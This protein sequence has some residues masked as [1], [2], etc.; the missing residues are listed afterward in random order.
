MGCRLDNLQS[1]QNRCNA[2]FVDKRCSFVTFTYDR[3][4]LKYNDNALY[5][6]LSQDEI[7][8]W[9]DNLRH[10][11]KNTP[12]SHYHYYIV[13]EYGGIFNRPHYHSLFFGL[14]FKQFEHFF[15]EKWKNGL[16]KTLPILAGGVRYVVDYLS[17]TQLGEQA[18][19]AYDNNFIERPFHFNSKGLGFDWFA[20]HAD[21]IADTS[22]IKCGSRLVPVPS[23]YVNMFRRL[24]FDNLSAI[25]KQKIINFRK[26]EELAKSNG[27]LDY[28]QYLDYT[29]KA[30]YLSLKN[31]YIEAGTPP[32]LDKALEKSSSL[33][34]SK[35]LYDMALSALEV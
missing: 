28:Q 34:S 14:D 12:F 22:C 2:E 18:V 21:E 3:Y 25:Y 11:F 9:N 30:K 26:K 5:P 19:K 35:A 4:H 8:K 33:L 13:G 32:I 31:K 15:N 7:H 27:F 16:V 20:T 29:C 10:Y 24:D 6:T 17:K 1:W 23:Y